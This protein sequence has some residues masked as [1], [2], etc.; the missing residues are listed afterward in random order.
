MCKLTVRQKVVV[1]ESLASKFEWIDMLKLAQNLDVKIP[2]E[3]KRE[4]YEFMLLNEIVPSS[5]PQTFQELKV[6]TF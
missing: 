3:F 1:V 5:E 6:K 2:L 4:V